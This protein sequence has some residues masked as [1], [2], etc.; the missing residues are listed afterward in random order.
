MLKEIYKEIYFAGYSI[1]KNIQS[2]MELRFS[3]WFAIFGM[4]LNN[5]AFLIIWISFGKIA[6]DMGGWQAIDY[7]LAIGIGTVAFGI[8]FA[9]GGGL[10]ELGPIIKKGDFD[11]FLLSP[12]NVLVR[13]ST[14]KFLVH[15]LGDLLFGIISVGTWIF[16]TGN[17]SWFVVINILFFTI[18]STLLWYYYSVLV[19][20]V[21]FYFADGQTIVQGLF[22]LL[23]TPSIFYGGAFTGWLRNFF[24]FIIPSF[25]LGNIAIEVIKNPTW[26][27]YIIV[28]AITLFWIVFALYIFRISVRRY[29]SS[30]FINFG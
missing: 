3:F 1:Y 29:E 20:A 26:Q 2:S 9:L 7:L 11:K 28:C 27:M 17:L 19:H 23:I 24:I 25:L 8:S 6:G 18:I 15:A 10:R 30:N 21:L 14:S 16:L 13:V 4:A 5:V 12:K 22:E